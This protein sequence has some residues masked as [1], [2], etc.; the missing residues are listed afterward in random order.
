[1]P[2]CHTK[3]FLF[4]ILV[5]FFIFL[6]TLIKLQ[7]QIDRI[8]SNEAKKKTSAFGKKEDPFLSEQAG[9]QLQKVWK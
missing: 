2:R 6:L 8:E 7:T 4:I 1:M 3:L 9:K 5:S